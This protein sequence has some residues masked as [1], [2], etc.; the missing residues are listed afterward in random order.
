MFDQQC[1]LN[2]INIMSLLKGL[3]R[4]TQKMTLCFSDFYTTCSVRVHSHVFGQTLSP[5]GKIP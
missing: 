3:N 5:T 2:S 1:K 4:H